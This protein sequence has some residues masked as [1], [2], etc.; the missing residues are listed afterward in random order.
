MVANMAINSVS[1]LT[2]FY[3]LYS[4]KIRIFR[5][6]LK[7]FTGSLVVSVLLCYT[8]TVYQSEVLFKAFVALYLCLLMSHI[9]HA[10][11]MQRDIFC[12]Q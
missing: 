10:M 3:A 7:F 5:V 6:F 9:N 4:S 11:Q 12:Y 2:G 8:S 1:Y